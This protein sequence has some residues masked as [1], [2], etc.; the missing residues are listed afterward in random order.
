MSP[1]PSSALR[2]TGHRVGVVVRAKNPRGTLARLATY[3][4]EFRARLYVVGVLIIVYTGLGLVGPYL[5][6]VALDRF[7]AMHDATGLGRIAGLMLAA[8][9]SNNLFQ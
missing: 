1:Q 7:I 8:F 9:L 2:P 3:F 5:M 6:G 4:G